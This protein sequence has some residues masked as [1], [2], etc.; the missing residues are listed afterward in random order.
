MTNKSP[1]SDEILTA[2]L[3]GEIP[4]EKLDAMSALIAQDV[5]L[6]DRLGR[7]QFEFDDVAHA[8]QQLRVPDFSEQI[9]V[10]N[11]AANRKSGDEKRPILWTPIRTTIAAGIL[12]AAFAAGVFVDLLKSDVNNSPPIQVAQMKTGWRQSVADYVSLYTPDTLNRRW[13]S[14]E[15][16]EKG[17]A[18]LSKDLDLPLNTENVSLGDL[19][20]VGGQILGLR[21]K[22]LGQLAYLYQGNT[23]FAFCIIQG[24]KGKKGMQFENRNGLE[25]AHWSTESHGFMVIGDIPRE[26]L[27]KIAQSFSVRF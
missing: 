6:Q 16:L 21:G 8:F 11:R 12:V 20:F 4:A 18:L 15:S 26:E 9:D 19:D 13:G 7:L 14:S 17:L 24:S 22:P 25:I 23:P 27:G 3:D 5:E 2:Y 10:I 1:V